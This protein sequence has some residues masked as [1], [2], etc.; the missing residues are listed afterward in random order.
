MLKNRPKDLKGGIP[1]YNASR[2]SESKMDAFKLGR[3]AAH[4]QQQKEENEQTAMMNMIQQQSLQQKEMKLTEMMQ[5]LQAMQSSMP[6]I[7]GGGPPIPPDMGPP[8]NGMPP[9]GPDG[10]PQG[11]GGPMGPGDELAEQP[12]EGPA[13][14]PEFDV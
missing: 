6:A 1:Q 4:L 3:Q 9:L 5:A 14:P 13:A 7:G 8:E 12:P 10:E 2:M 11:M